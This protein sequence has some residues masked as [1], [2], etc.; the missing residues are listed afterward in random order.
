MIN[1]TR[2]LALA[3][4]ILVAGAVPPMA[5]RVVA[6]VVSRETASRA[7]IVLSYSPVNTIADPLTTRDFPATVRAATT[8]A[9]A[10]F[11]AMSGTATAYIATA[12]AGTATARAITTTPTI[13]FTPGVTTTP[14]ITP[15]LPAEWG[16]DALCACHVPAFPPGSPE[17]ERLKAEYVRDVLR[18]WAS[19]T[20]LVASP[21]PTPSDTPT[22]TVTPSQTPTAA[23]TATRTDEPTPTVRTVG[24]S[25]QLPTVSHTQT[26]WIVTATPPPT[27]RAWLPFVAV[28]RRRR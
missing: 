11:I 21:T 1:R 26:P 3:A 19:Q 2:P 20:A 27:W 10:A 7:T 5:A 17:C 15:T 18:A 13:T 28:W 4:A 16:V 23:P 24:T 22:P 9:T 14:T 8:T 12:L 6:N 25:T